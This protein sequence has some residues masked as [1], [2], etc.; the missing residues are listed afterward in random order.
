MTVSTLSPP[1]TTGAGRG[2]FRIFGVFAR[3]SIARA[4]GSAAVVGLCGLLFALGSGAHAIRDEMLAMRH[5]EARHIVETAASVARS[6]VLK[7]Q[8]GQMTDEAARAAAL[9]AISAVR[10]AGGNYV[11]VFKDDGAMIAHSNPAL[12]G[13]N[14]WNETD[15]AGAFFARR[16]IEAAQAGGAFA[17]Y[18][19]PKT[20]GA[21]PLPKFTYALGV[22]EWRWALGAGLW[23]DD[24]DTSF[25]HAIRGSAVTFG[26]VLILLA[27]LM[28]TAI[29]RA[30]GF[31]QRLSRE[32]RALAAGDLDVEIGGVKRSDEIGEAAR[33]LTVFR[34]TAREKQALE[35]RADDERRRADADRLDRA[36]E[37]QEVARQA[38][39][40]EREIVSRSIGGELA[41]LAEKDLSHRL[42]T[43]L[44][45]AYRKLQNDLNHALDRIGAD[46]Q[47]VAAGADTIV[48][49][50]GEIAS[51]SSDLSQRTEHQASS[52]AQT[53]AALGNITNAV[54][55]TAEGAL[56]ARDVVRATTGEAE[57]SRKVVASAIGAMTKIDQSA[58]EIGQIVSVIDEIAFQTNLLA[59]NAGVEAARAG[60]AGRGFAVVASEVRALAQRS[61]D[62]AR[63]IKGL[64]TGSNTQVSEG[65]TLVRE[66]GEALS[67]IVEGVSNINALVADIAASAETQAH[68][69]QEVNAAVREMDHV[70]QQNAAMAEEATAASTSL[71]MEGKRLSALIG[72]FKL[73]ADDAR[74]PLGR[75]KRAA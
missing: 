69:M 39:D 73:H 67:R 61:A 52:L 40:H 54:R 1:D 50:V 48:S 63:E 27:A 59:L 7:A 11:F 23:A 16:I 45:D 51:A 13:R 46:L 62:A 57:A 42:T 19:W 38:I 10:F 2:R 55:K 20:A 53:A 6:Y 21:T 75:P 34:D 68:G 5:E 65:V 60:D 66:T 14:Y 44:P 58:R 37:A 8:S 43:D 22:P 17:D 18:L 4:L 70:T 24:V 28:S 31:L 30:Q 74:A 26:V 71:A 15:P 49:G 29:L 25:L 64:I 36:R 41:R 33:A 47:N 12:I 32:M 56:L 9:E 35:R 72:A 3:M